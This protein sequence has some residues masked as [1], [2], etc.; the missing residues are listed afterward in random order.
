MTGEEPDDDGFGGVGFARKDV[1]GFNGGLDGG[2]VVNCPLL[3][4]AGEDWEDELVVDNF[5]NLPRVFLFF[6]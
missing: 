1:G 2:D 6:R 5:H 4:G 3:V